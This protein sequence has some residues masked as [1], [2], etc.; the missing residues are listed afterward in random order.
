METR[1]E[2]EVVFFLKEFKSYYVVWKHINVHKIPS[3]I[4]SLNRTMQYGNGASV[5]AVP[6]QEEGLNRTMQYGNA[7]KRASAV[8]IPTV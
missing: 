3:G 4:Q 5:D 6:T 7:M 1:V 8:P 2:N